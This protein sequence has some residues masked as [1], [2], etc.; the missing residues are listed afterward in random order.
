VPV[1]VALSHAGVVHHEEVH[2]KVVRARSLDLI[3]IRA[4]EL[5]HLDA[6]SFTWSNRGHVVLGISPVPGI[7]A[8][9][10]VPGV[11]VKA[12][13]RVA[14]QAISA[15]THCQCRPQTE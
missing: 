13:D 14:R 11:A 7:V 9:W 3:M 6:A 15:S 8:A 12:V 1:T 2:L 4:Y 10:V 5:D